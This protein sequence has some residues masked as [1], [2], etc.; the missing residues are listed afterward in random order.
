MN[1]V[2][3]IFFDILFMIVANEDKEPGSK[4]PKN[5]Q[6]Y[7]QPETFP[8]LIIG[9]IFSGKQGFFFNSQD[10]SIVLTQMKISV[11]GKELP[12]FICGCKAL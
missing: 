8:F 7:F 12:V 3:N 4:L 11:C 5:N 9:R 2:N 10:N 1:M 6:H